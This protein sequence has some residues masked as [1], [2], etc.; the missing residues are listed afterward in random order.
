M[1]EQPT[2]T[3]KNVPQPPVA[4]Q[5]AVTEYRDI[6]AKPLGSPDFAS[7]KH[8]NPNMSVRWVNCDVGEKHSTMRF[9]MAQAQ[10]FVACTPDEVVTVLPNGKTNPCPPALIKD[11]RVIYGDVILMKLPR[12]D[13]LGALK[14][15]EERAIKRI[16]RPGTVLE[17]GRTEHQ[18]SDERVSPSNAF[19]DI[20]RNPKVAAKVQP[21]VPPIAEIEN[22][23]LI[24]D[25]TVP[26]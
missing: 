12:N 11:G 18:A 3:S 17:G 22:Q 1:P 6:V 8:K 9:N 24:V 5:Q 13:Y 15:N 16:Q 20:T 4:P 14:Y 23:G 19:S 7:M 26:K 10:G 2:I 21:Y 25:K